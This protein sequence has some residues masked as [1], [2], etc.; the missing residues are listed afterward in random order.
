M[1]LPPHDRRPSILWLRC[2]NVREPDFSTHAHLVSDKH[3]L[4]PSDGRPASSRPLARCK[5][6]VR[7]PLPALWYRL[8]LARVLLAGATAIGAVI[9]VSLLFGLSDRP[10]RF[11]GEPEARAAASPE[12]I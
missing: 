10:R 3:S 2:R 6:G 7:L 12:T 11:A 8:H 9:A 1:A 5:T 4:R